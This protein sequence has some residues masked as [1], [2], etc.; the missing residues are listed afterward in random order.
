MPATP[1]ADMVLAGVRRLLYSQPLLTVPIG[2]DVPDPLAILRGR[3]LRHRRR[4][5]EDVAVGIDVAQALVSRHHRSFRSIVPQS[6]IRQQS[7]WSAR[8]PFGV[9][10]HD[11]RTAATTPHAAASL[12]R[13][14]AERQLGRDPVEDERGVRSHRVVVEPTD[15]E[16]Q[17]H[18]YGDEEHAQD[19]PRNR[20]TA[21]SIF[22]WRRRE[23]TGVAVHIRMMP[24]GAGQCERGGRGGGGSWVLGGVGR[25]GGGGRRG[26][27]VKEGGG[28]RG[29]GGRRGDGRGE[30]MGGGEGEVRGG[31]R[32]RGGEG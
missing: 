18:D 3:V 21:K 14:C 19:D 15:G 24:A 11:A 2:L 27:E 7:H 5:L 22:G 8:R 28:G 10:T 32:G 13:R 25:G 29:G 26:A 1:A 9:Q 23:G 31:E 12:G 16:D 17:E 30:T 6:P 4:M 20:H